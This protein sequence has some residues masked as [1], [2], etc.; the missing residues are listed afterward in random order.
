[1][2]ILL[3][4]LLCL[5]LVEACLITRKRFEEV[6]APLI[7]FWILLAYGL[8]VFQ[9]LP[10]IIVFASAVALLGA[11]CVLRIYPSLRSV[12]R[13]LCLY[14][15]TPGFL[16]F[17]VLLVFYLYA[18]QPRMVLHN[19]DIN[20]WA[21]EARS[22]FTRN[23]LVGQ[24]LHLSPRFMSYPPGMAIFQTIG[25]IIAGEWS[26]PTIFLMLYLF[27]SAF[28]LHLMRRVTWKT[29]YWVPLWLA[30]IVG[31]PTVFNSYTYV[32]LGVD[33][34]M[35]LCLGYALVQLWRMRC[36]KDDRIF[37]A[38]SVALSLSVLVLLKQVGI[39]WAVMALCFLPVAQLSKHGV[40]KRLITGILALPVLVFASWTLFCQLRGLNSINETSLF[41][42]FAS[43]LQGSWVAPQNLNQLPGNLW[44][45]I[46][47]PVAGQ[48]GLVNLYPPL[49]IPK[50]V[51]MLLL[52]VYPLLLIRLHGLSTQDA[53][54]LFRYTLAMLAAFL[55][56]FV[57]SLL[58]A[59]YG[60]AE[61][62]L[63]SWVWLH[64]VLE[65]YLAPSLIGL[66]MLGVTLCGEALARPLPISIVTNS[67]ITPEKTVSILRFKTVSNTP[68]STKR[69]RALPFAGVAATCLL[70]AFSCNWQTVSQYL[71][72]D[73]YL[74]TEPEDLFS[75]ALEENGWT[76]SLADPAHAI[77]LYG[78]GAYPEHAAR[79]QY[80]IAPTKL[81]LVPDTE[82]TDGAFI[83]L[84][85]AT[86][87]THVVCADE[88][89]ALFNVAA[90]YCE[91][92]W[93][94]TLTAY[95]VDWNGNI[96]VLTME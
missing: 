21:L 56:G 90:T 57:L 95:R 58:T 4:F 2:F 16:C 50:V 52:L 54:A 42:N 75:F 20:Y 69:I 39:M 61:A 72:P 27:Y 86:D 63:N 19:D 22:L 51:W 1:M 25:L 40:P 41:S 17:A 68:A 3:L 64:Y 59:F 55:V 46:A 26:E 28:L 73:N 45:A 66:A 8:S 35:G 89:N 70:F 62:Y 94:E 33:S 37:L 32:M 36:N 91:D 76:D 7:C 44:K 13:A 24:T 78:V 29:A 74:K 53:R 6:L 87:A 9:A 30:F 79:L 85:R 92:S 18:C 14:L 71:I 34:A 48:D 93:L 83:A 67:A 12:L 77:V 47:W 23:G 5:T 11:V 82:M 43:L 60:E 88:D 96:P 10:L 65:R 15:F 84:L 81:I 49:E 80:A 38:I 31:F